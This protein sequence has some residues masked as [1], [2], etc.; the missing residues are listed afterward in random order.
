MLAQ[1]LY[2]RI[3]AAGNKLYLSGRIRTLY[4][5][6][7]HEEGLDIFQLPTACY[8]DYYKYNKIKRS[9]GYLVQIKN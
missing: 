1:L 4:I 5:K 6:N 3:V 2:G 8:K 9:G 7:E